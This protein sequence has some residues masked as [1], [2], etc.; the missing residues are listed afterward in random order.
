MS[1]DEGYD[2]SRSARSVTSGV[3]AVLRRQR[4]PARTPSAS[5]TSSS[6][7]GP[8]AVG[9][10][11]PVSYTARA[12]PSAGASDAGS[13]VIARNPAARGSI[14]GS[15]CAAATMAAEVKGRPRSRSSSLPP[16]DRL[17]VEGEVVLDPRPD[18]RVAPG[19]ERPGD[20]GRFS[21]AVEQLEER[22]DLHARHGEPPACG[23]C[24][25]GHR[26][27]DGDE[28][29]P[30]ELPPVEVEQA[31]A[32]HDAARRCGDTRVRPLG[33]GGDRPAG[34]VEGI[35]VAK[36]AESGVGGGPDDHRG[37]VAVLVREDVAVVA[38]GTCRSRRTAASADPAPRRVAA[39]RSG[40]RRPC[41]RRR[42][43]PAA[44]PAGRAGR[45]RR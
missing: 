24:S 30:T 35:E 28:T 2:A 14:R 40:T 3:V 36:D 19:A 9:G 44:V 25:G 39:G 26:V 22:T 34:G 7:V 27:A 12:S 15:A 18:P 1:R 32:D 4:E 21:A 42:R 13:A 6:R 17:G 43:A 37:D 16:A 38:R 8:S 5:A 41:R 33:E 23:R 31:T 20:P 45:S 11:Q 10:R 29:G